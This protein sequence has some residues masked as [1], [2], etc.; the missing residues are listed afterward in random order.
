M[1]INLKS[2]T[3]NLGVG[4]G[5]AAAGIAIALAS[6]YG[7]PPRMPDDLIHRARIERLRSGPSLEEITRY[8]GDDPAKT[9]L[10]EGE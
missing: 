3:V 5:L 8:F 10:P 6:G 2:W 1:I 4:I 7:K 9:Y